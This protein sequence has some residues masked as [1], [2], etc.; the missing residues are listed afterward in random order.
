MDCPLPV[1]VVVSKLDVLRGLH[2]TSNRQTQ[3]RVVCTHLRTELQQG[4]TYGATARSYFD[5][6]VL[7]NPTKQINRILIGTQR[8]RQQYYLSSQ[9]NA[10]GAVLPE[11]NF[12]T[13]HSGLP[14]PRG[15]RRTTLVYQNST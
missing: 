13:I 9:P 7:A 12:G 11:T 15:P 4:P 1:G 14:S 3:L 5:C 10:C 8:Q 6:D 2:V